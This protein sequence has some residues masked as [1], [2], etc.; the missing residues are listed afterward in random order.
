MRKR[1]MKKA[2]I[3]ITFLALFIIA[4]LFA[5]PSEASQRNLLTSDT[6]EI[7][8]GSESSKGSESSENKHEP[9][10]ES[11]IGG[12]YAMSGQIENVGYLT[13]LY[14]A[15]NGL[16]TSEANYILGAS[17]GFIWIGGYS[18]IIKYDGSKFVRLQSDYGLTSSRGLFEDSTGRI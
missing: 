17:D 14:D 6:S 2:Y 7:S 3:A 4:G 5:M 12:A 16:P 8:Q 15:T 1:R 10:I 13:K 18:G 9:S 11:R